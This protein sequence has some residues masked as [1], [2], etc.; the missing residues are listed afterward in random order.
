MLAMSTNRL[1][2]IT[3]CRQQA[4][5]DHPCRQTGWLGSPHVDNRLV[6][7]T[8]CRQQAGWDHPMSTTGWLGSPHVD[9]RL[10]G[11]ISFTLFLSKR[12]LIAFFC[13]SF[14]GVLLNKRNGMIHALL[15]I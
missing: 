3:P 14:N 11:M 2:G 12:N 6:G 5:W 13:F 7:I 4:G 10:V 15:A 8:P 1:V 9:N